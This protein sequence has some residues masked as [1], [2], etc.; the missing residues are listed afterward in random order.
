MIQPRRKTLLDHQ[1]TP[2]GDLGYLL[3]AAFLFPYPNRI[4]G[5]LSADGK[6]LSTSWQ[7]H[8]ITLPANNIGAGA[9]AG[10]TLCMG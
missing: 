7:G 1:D 2:N 3:G 6:T 9:G 8:Q 10:G 5:T 4:R